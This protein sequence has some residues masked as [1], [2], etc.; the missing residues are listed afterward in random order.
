MHPSTLLKKSTLSLMCAAALVSSAASA[1]V[2][3]TGTSYTYNLSTTSKLPG[4]T[5]LATITLTQTSSSQVGV[6][7][8][9]ANNYYF[10]GTGKDDTSPTFAFSLL[11]AYKL[12][13]VSYTGSNFSVMTYGSYNLT[14]DGMFTN[15]LRLSSNGTSARVGTPLDFSVSLQSGISL[16]AF[17]LSGAKNDGQPGGFAFAAHIGNQAG[18]TGSIGFVGLTPTNID[19]PIVS[20]PIEGGSNGVPEPASVALMGLGLGLTGLASLRKRRPA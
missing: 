11:D 18:L 1:T 14:P 13:T 5:T 9:L 7:V 6:R 3:P 8:A 2:I 15:G 16:D 20:G 17:A 4:S 10:A 19:T 12:A